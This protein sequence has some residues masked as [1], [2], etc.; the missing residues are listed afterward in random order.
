M[1]AL[2]EMLWWPVVALL[3]AVMCLGG[4]WFFLRTLLKRHAADIRATG[5]QAKDEIMVRMLWYN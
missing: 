4:I 5:R 1:Q 3:A 2:V